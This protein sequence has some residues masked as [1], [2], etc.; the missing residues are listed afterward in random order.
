MSLMAPG[1]GLAA[2]DGTASSWSKDSLPLKIV[3]E[4]EHIGAGVSLRT[5]TDEPGRRAWQRLLEEEV[6]RGHGGRGL[7]SFR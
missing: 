1:T 6:D 2:A 5:R 4:P 7:G 3:P